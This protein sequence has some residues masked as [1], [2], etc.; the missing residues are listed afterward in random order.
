MN[1]K[2]IVSVLILISGLIFAQTEE[3]KFGAEITLT[4]KTQI[5]EILAEPDVY[6]G[7]TVLVEG[8]ILEVCPMKGCWMELKSDDGEGK[9]KIKVKDDEIVFPMDAVGDFAV[10]QGTVYKIELSQEAAVDYY[11]HLAEEKGEEF[12]PS[13]I[14]GPMT[15][16]QIKGI[17]AEITELKN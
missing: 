16:Y 5:S 9:I 7:Q 13:T 15:I 2:V 10:V 4:E 1:F 3:N 17:G 6:L 14:T 8:E 11:E 12:D